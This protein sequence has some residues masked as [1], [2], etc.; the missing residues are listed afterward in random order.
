MRK[1]PAFQCCPLDGTAMAK[2]LLTGALFPRAVRVAA[3]G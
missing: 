1:E 3:Q 2:A